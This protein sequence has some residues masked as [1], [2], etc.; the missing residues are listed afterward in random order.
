MYNILPI[1]SNNG[2]EQTSYLIYDNQAMILVDCGFE[3]NDFFALLKDNGLQ[4]RTLNCVL[5][6]HA[7]FDHIWAL[8]EIAD[9]YACPIYL[10]VGC[11][12]YIYDSIKN[13]SCYFC[14][15][16]LKKIDPSLIVEINDDDL[17]NFGK[18]SFKVIFTPGHSNCSVCYMFYDSLFTG[19]TILNGTVGRCDLFGGCQGKLSSSLQKIKAKEF[20]IAYPGHGD[21]INS[22]QAKAICSFY[23]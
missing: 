13:A 7:H 22:T 14:K 21:P 2:L 15:F 5:L 10:H 9:L 11:T 18:M 20:K 6:T 12:D 17:I 16:K 4:S 8:N 1:K 23:E 3:I 19:D